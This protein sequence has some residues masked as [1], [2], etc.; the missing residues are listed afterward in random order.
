MCVWTLFDDPNPSDPSASVTAFSR[1]QEHF[2]FVNL[3]SQLVGLWKQSMNKQR[4]LL[5]SRTGLIA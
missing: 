3:L 1:M 2:Y 5:C 4:D